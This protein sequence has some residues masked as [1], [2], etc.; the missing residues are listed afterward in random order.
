MDKQPFE[1]HFILVEE[2]DNHSP[3]LKDA[4]RDIITP[5]K[6][7]VYVSDQTGTYTR[8]MRFEESPWSE[9]LE[10]LVE[11]LNEGYYA[12]QGRMMDKIEF[13]GDDEDA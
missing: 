3:T 13:G 6:Y 5:S 10:F 12:F 11:Y 8:L 4:W 2:R 9:N 7:Y 1:P